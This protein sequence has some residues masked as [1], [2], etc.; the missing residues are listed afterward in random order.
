MRSRA[1][2]RTS[3][4]F[5]PALVHLDGKDALDDGVLAATG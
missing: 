3:A 1:R 2:E 4:R 5:G